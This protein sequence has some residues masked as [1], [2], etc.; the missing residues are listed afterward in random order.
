MGIILS[1]EALSV[2][3]ILTVEALG[4][5]LSQHLIL[6]SYAGGFQ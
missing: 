2:E 3:Q 4:F 1:V 5:L 6:P